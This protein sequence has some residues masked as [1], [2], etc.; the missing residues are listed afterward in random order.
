[1][2]IDVSVEDVMAV[3]REVEEAQANRMS[4]VLYY[5]SVSCPLLLLVYSAL[6]HP[7]C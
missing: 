4:V 7:I 1:M 2:E 6:T 3:I 5:L